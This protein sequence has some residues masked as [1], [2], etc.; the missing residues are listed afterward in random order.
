[1]RALLVQANWMKYVNAGRAATVVG[2]LRD[3]G[4]PSHTDD[5]AAAVT[6]AWMA[7]LTGDQAALAAHLGV[8]HEFRDYGPLPDGTR[9]VESAIAMIQ[10]L[11]GFGGPVEM[12]AGAQRAVEL[13]T[14]GRS[15]FY[16]IANLSL[17]HAAYVAGD[18][19]RAGSLL[20][21]ATHNDSAQAIIRVLSASIHSLVEAENGHQ[22]RALELADLAMD[23]VETRGL[24][25]MPQASM[26]FTARAQAYAA[27]GD[28]TEARASVDHGLAVRRRNP[29]L[30]PWPTMHHLLVAARIAMDEGQFAKA[31]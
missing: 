3:L 30:S 4:S 16:A 6:A 9:S 31:R 17:G 25:A 11:F 8:L 10:G 21:K 2:W 15:P 26:A 23:I 1:M 14:D 22:D 24:H 5:P 20:A 13:E 29:T 12:A 28:M 7:A 27:A 18:L 19:E